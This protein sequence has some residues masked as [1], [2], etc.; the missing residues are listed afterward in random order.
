MSDKDFSKLSKSKK[1]I[2]CFPALNREQASCSTNKF[3]DNG[4]IYIPAAPHR[5]KKRKTN[6]GNVGY[7]AANT[8]IKTWQKKLT[9]GSKRRGGE[10]GNGRSMGRQQSIGFDPICIMYMDRY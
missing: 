9:Q 1:A 10:G 3:S 2:H 4:A 7:R 6:V 8:Y 5:K